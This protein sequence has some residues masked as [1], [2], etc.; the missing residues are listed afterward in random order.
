MFCFNTNITHNLT[1]APKNGSKVTVD[2]YGK[3]FLSA[4]DVP[5]LVGD[6]GTDSQFANRFMKMEVHGSLT[7]RGRY[8]KNQVHYRKVI[9]TYVYEFLMKELNIYKNMT[10]EDGAIL[11]N[12]ILGKYRKKYPLVDDDDITPE[13]QIDSWSKVFLG[14][15]AKDL[16]KDKYNQY[17]EAGYI[18]MN[19]K[20]HLIILNVS[21]LWKE[22]MA[23]HFNN[24]P[25]MV[26]STT[27]V[28]AWKLTKTRYVEKT[29]GVKLWA[30]NIGLALEH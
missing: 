6:N 15:I 29:T 23:I 7:A 10:D 25:L 8:A 16:K 12:K 11:A 5:S 14:R 3:I 20:G 21:A 18:A 27:P 1:L 17:V 24:D 19:K 4:N 13:D 9:T 22:F 26:R 28:R 30:K 2:L